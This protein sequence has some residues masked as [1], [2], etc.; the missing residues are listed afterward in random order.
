MTLI[1]V[2]LMITI[3][4][5]IGT[6]VTN[7]SISNTKQISKTEQEMQ[8][9]DLAEMGVIYYK[10]VFIENA[11]QT[12]T[13]NIEQSIETIEEMNKENNEKKKDVEPIEINPTN[14]LTYL[15]IRKNDFL[16]GVIIS[17]SIPVDDNSSYEIKYHVAQVDDK[18]IIVI[19]ESIGKFNQN[20]ETEK[21]KSITGTITLDVNNSLIS[22]YLD[23]SGV[24]IIKKP[25]GLIESY[26][27]NGQLKD[28]YFYTTEL[29][30]SSKVDY[31]INSITTLVN[32]SLQLNA[33]KK[34][35]GK[36]T[37]L[38]ITKNANFG[39][40]N[41][42]LDTSRLY[43]GGNATFG[44]INGGI[45]HNSILFI[46]QDATFGAING[47]VDSSSLVCV[48][49]NIYG[50]ISENGVNIISRIKS[51]EA[52]QKSCLNNNN[53]TQNLADNIADQVKEMTLKYQ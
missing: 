6:V 26:Q 36:N 2:L 17:K 9:V 1:I 39:E 45:K 46:G 41:G 52:Y 37:L 42:N 25:E 3:F 33:S 22:A 23:G 44:N 21:T 8:A 48:G 47:G 31:N 53:N 11:K 32:G 40:L 51:P 13:L 7:L 28:G 14:I 29:Y 12:L 34:Q 24:D 15:N 10:N 27:Y 19:F 35:I 50:G 49:G 20:Q 18:K 30:D 38:Y 4:S 5:I 43:I 16:P